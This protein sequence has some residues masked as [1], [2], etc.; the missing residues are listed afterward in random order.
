MLRLDTIAVDELMRRGATIDVDL[1][2]KMVNWGDRLMFDRLVLSG[3][4]V[5]KLI[6]VCHPERAW[7]CASSW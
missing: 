6:E 5:C 4:D 7:H 2:V 1:V 3:F